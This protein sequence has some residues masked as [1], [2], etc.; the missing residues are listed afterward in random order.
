MLDERLKR[1]ISAKVGLIRHVGPQ[2]R[3]GMEPVPPYL[4]VANLAHFDFRMAEPGDRVGAGKGP[5]ED[6]AIAAAIGEAVERYCAFQWD[7]ARTFVARWEEVALAAI[8]PPE[9]V[10][11]SDAQY[12][13]KGWRYRRWTEA[14]E[15]AW[16]HGSEL[17]SARQIA[18]PASLVYL[19]HPPPRVEDYFSSSTSNGLAAGSTLPRAI[20]AALCELMERDAFLVAWMN[21]LP[22]IELDL[23]ASGELA[24]RLHRHY[25]RFSV[26]IR[27]F[28]LPSDLP[29]TTV[30][31][32]SIDPHSGRPAHVVGLG[33]HPDPE[34]ALRKALFELCQ[35][36]PAEARRYADK[37]PHGRLTRYEDV[38]TLDDHSAFLSMPEH[39]AEF[40]FLWR[41]GQLARI[42]DFANP[43]TG[44]AEQDLDHCV[45]SLTEAGHRVAW[46]DLTLPD[47]AESG[48]HAVRA[49]VTGLQP[50]HFGH[51][52]ERLGG[53]RLFEL[54]VK[55]GLATRATS[56]DE[57]NPCPHPLA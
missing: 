56:V 48:I 7:P 50:I 20:L 2:P 34:V 33:C 32:L 45:R 31:A 4:A 53:Q 42:A 12:R 21:R 38:K 37:P 55:L 30:A 28:V 17:P 40:Q 36:R 14:D 29:A 25:A 41:D 24:A 26:E 22:A 15:T 51:G 18:V 23:P 8:S 49:V 19:V 35:G 6:E 57:L 1:M 10:L 46:I 3:S 54:P 27:A 39:F 9:F 11:Y 47:I 5:T 16:I 43:S 13:S 52:Q 44:D